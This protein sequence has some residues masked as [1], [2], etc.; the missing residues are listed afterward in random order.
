MFT[1]KPCHECGGDPVNHR[2]A[3]AE[4]LLESAFRPIETADRHAALRTSL[5]HTYDG[6]VN[7]YAPVVFSVLARVG[8]GDF[9][10][11]IDDRDFK[12]V[13]HC[14]WSAADARGIR[15]QQFRPFGMVKD[16]FIASYGRETLVYERMPVPPGRGRGRPLI[17]DKD[18][19]KQALLAHALP[20]ARGAAC[21]SEQEAI[22]LFRTLRKPV[23]AKPHR[24]S[25]TRHTTLHINDEAELRH[26]FRVARQ[27]S[28]L[29]MIEEELRGHVYR[30]TVI[31]GKLIATI[32]REPPTIAGDGKSTIAELIARENEDPRRHGPVFSP[33]AIT[34]QVLKELAWQHLSLEDIPREGQT[35]RLHQKVNWGGGGTTTD[36]TLDVHPDNRALFEQIAEIL[37]A[38]IVGID[39]IAEDIGIS[40]REQE[41]CG[42]IET[43]SMPF[44]DNHHLPFH[45]Q[46]RDVAG[47]IWEMVFP[48]MP[49]LEKNS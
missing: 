38:P 9:T 39:F 25:G 31:D 47:A 21:R 13:T 43:N 3:F 48:D 7:A 29:V 4:A 14:M 45:G 6:I 46:P 24:G 10:Y 37:Q 22:D 1:P 49:K 36:V 28:P 42:I 40:W 16:V 11:E 23:I 35:V 44:I 18:R 19:L 15:L 33:I 17:D 26:A 27:L 41:L 32:R 2:I 5:R 20:V 8:L 30:P 34:P 12:F